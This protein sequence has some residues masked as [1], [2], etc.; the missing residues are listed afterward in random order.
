MGDTSAAVATDGR[1]LIARV[2]T[3]RLCIGFP[4]QPQVS[5]RTLPLSHQLIDGPMPLQESW[6]RGKFNLDST[7][8]VIPDIDG[9]LV[10]S[11]ES[12]V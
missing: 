7:T 8:L 1:L 10:P 2:P 4:I 9:M 3:Q 11:C 6:V 5:I 12:P